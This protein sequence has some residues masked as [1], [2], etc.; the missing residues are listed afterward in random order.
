MVKLSDYQ[1]P[2]IQACLSVL[3]EIMTILG[4]F[5]DNVVIVGGNVPQL[6]IPTA[7]ERHSGSLDI[8]LAFDHKHISASTY[9]TIMKTLKSRSYY[10]KDD[11]EPFT[12]YRDIESENGN[13]ITVKVDLLSGEYGG[14]GKRHR[15]QR[16]QDAKARK[17]RGCDLVFE[18]ANE[19]SLSGTLPSGAKNEVI[20]K[21]PSVGA[22]LAMKGMALWDRMKEK[23]AYDIYY[24]CKHFPGGLPAIEKAIKPLMAN[25]LAQEGLGKI[26]AKFLTVDSIG[27]S[28]VA[29]FM[30]IIDKEEQE[31][32]KRESFELLNTLMD[33]LSIQPFSRK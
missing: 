5:R 26:H 23:D 6:L 20:V 11:G 14:T 33:R 24:C 4:E 7:E 12:F 15:H 30:E 13:V 21:I 32:I 19:I 22:F 9:S 1:E 16:V 8:D 29:D 25:K 10:Q 3:L 31:R 2:G 28:W 27:P 18:H 17:A